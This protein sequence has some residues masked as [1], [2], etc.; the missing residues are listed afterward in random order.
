MI[1]KEPWSEEEERVLRES[2]DRFGNKWAEIAKM[3]PGRTDNAIKNHWN[4]SKR[5]LKR[6]TPAPLQESA[7]QGSPS[8]AGDASPT[9]QPTDASPRTTL[10]P[11]DATRVPSV[12]PEIPAPKYP[13]HLTGISNAAPA[14]M[15]FEPLRSLDVGHIHPDLHQ[16]ITAQAGTP[17]CCW[18]PPPPV[19]P[20]HM[21][22]LCQQSTLPPHH[23]QT[24]FAGPW[25]RTTPA[26]RY[27]WSSAAVNH[28]LVAPAGT[29]VSSGSRT[30]SAPNTIEP[31]T[32][33]TSSLEQLLAHV[34]GKRLLEPMTLSTAGAD[35][36]TPGGVAGRTR[37]ETAAMPAKR[38]RT[39]PKS[40]AQ[41][42]EFVRVQ[43]GVAAPP[44]PASKMDPRLQ[45]LADAALLQSICR[46]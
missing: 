41:R 40:E 22:L 25:T 9:A 19:P 35:S 36:G 6:N 18:T 39:R 7:E 43:Q 38:R 14:P 5:R 34:Q 2:H 37:P 20:V 10:V 30:L 12:V 17:T 46:V 24:G 11:S 16:Q 4:S 15:A 8:P 1:R 23:Q 33:K 29:A 26:Q 27:D 13:P 3:L 42:E 32:V 45:L 21:K 44:Q 28:N 31:P